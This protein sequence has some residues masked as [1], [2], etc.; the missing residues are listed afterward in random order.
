MPGYQIPN[1]ELGAVYYGKRSI[2]MKP[3]VRVKDSVADY[4]WWDG[5][6]SD[7]GKQGVS[8]SVLYL[9]IF[10]KTIVD[11]NTGPRVCTS[12]RTNERGGSA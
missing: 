1:N 5:G 10:S 8:C 11:S 12:E 4:Y 3:A 6:K 2:E 7:E 9:F